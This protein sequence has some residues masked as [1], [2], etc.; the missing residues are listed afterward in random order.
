MTVGFFPL[1]NP[2]GDPNHPCRLCGSVGELTRTHAPS[3]AS[4][5]RGHARPLGERI[6]PDGARTLELG[7]GPPGA[8][9]WGWYFCASCNGDTSKWE[10]EHLRWQRPILQRIHEHG[11]PR[12]LPPGEMLD[13]DPGAFVRALWAWMFALD[14]TLFGG[15][16]D[17]AAAVKSGDAVQPPRDLRLLLAATTSL[18]MW[19]SRQRDGYGVAFDLRHGGWQ[20][21]ESGLWSLEPELLELPR[22]VIS[23]PPFVL[24]L[25]DSARDVPLFDTAPW[26]TEAAG[27]RRAV[28]LLLPTVEMRRSPGHTVGYADIVVLQLQI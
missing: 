16:R 26:L 21:R 5:N 8:G 25:A 19:A 24:V 14:E 9:A 10:D 4:G 13:R 6:T 22:V 23:T 20:H 15:H 27:N 17:L 2:K 7:K 3:R 11:S 12:P 28:P 18:E 1:G